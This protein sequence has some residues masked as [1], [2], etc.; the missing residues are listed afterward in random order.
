MQET[1]MRTTCASGVDG[2][3]RVLVDGMHLSELDSLVLGRVLKDTQR[4][5]PQVALPD[6]VGSS[7]GILD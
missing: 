4:I 2:D 3:V 5:D 1:L 6:L 7:D